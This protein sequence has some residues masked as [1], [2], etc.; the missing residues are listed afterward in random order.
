MGVETHAASSSSTMEKFKLVRLGR[1]KTDEG[2]RA[3]LTP[4][5]VR[6]TINCVWD[7][8]RDCYHH[9]KIKLA[10]LAP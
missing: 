9:G 10:T 6:V 2:L 8:N 5:C 3:S 4:Y 7:G 1:I